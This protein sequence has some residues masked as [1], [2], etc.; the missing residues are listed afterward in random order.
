MKAYVRLD[1]QQKTARQIIQR[2][3]TYMAAKI[4]R[5]VG[6]KCHVAEHYTGDCANA[7]AAS[8]VIDETERRG[9]DLFPLE[10]TP[11]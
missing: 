6:F 7:D 5:D 2:E 10:G 4:L 11:E 3:Q 8:I 1:E 9:A